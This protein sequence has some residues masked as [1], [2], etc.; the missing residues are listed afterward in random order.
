[1]RRE[2]IEKNKT[3]KHTATWMGRGVK[4]G[5]TEG[6]KGVEKEKTKRDT[7]QVCVCVC[8]GRPDFRNKEGCEGGRQREFLLS[9]STMTAPEERNQEGDKEATRGESRRRR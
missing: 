2:K 9:T 8:V 6:R 4:S 3:T 7:K 1:M 5:D